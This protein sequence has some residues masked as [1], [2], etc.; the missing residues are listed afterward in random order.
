MKKLQTR[1]LFLIMTM[2][3]CTLTHVQAQQKTKQPL[4]P[5]WSLGHIIWEDS[6]NTEQG[7]QRLF[8]EY[9]D[10]D[11]SFFWRPNLLGGTPYFSLKHL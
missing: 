5:A 3:L 4:V 10:F 1:K 2:C 9:A 7:A 6:I 8:S 11:Y